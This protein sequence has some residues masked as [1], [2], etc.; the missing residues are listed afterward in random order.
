VDDAKTV[1]GI[2]IHYKT[3]IPE[4]SVLAGE[5]MLVQANLGDLLLKVL[6]QTEE[7]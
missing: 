5:I 4:K 6:M 3:D 2:V 1:D 7:E